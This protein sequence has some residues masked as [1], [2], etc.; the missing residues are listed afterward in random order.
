M[1]YDL[2]DGPAGLLVLSSAAVL[3][4]IGRECWP[5]H[6]TTRMIGQ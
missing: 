1:L 2:A 6:P 3:A 4:A 5:G